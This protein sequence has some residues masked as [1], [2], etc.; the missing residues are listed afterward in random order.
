[1][2]RLNTDQDDDDAGRFLKH[3]VRLFQSFGFDQ[4]FGRAYGCSGDENQERMAEGIYEKEK[5]A[6]NHVSLLGDK[7]KEDGQDGHGAGRRDE[8]EKKAEQKSPEMPRP[9]NRSRRDGEI[10]VKRPKKLQRP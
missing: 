4:L 1:M 8:A 2:R 7:G 10:Q 5:A 3:G 6:V 9:L